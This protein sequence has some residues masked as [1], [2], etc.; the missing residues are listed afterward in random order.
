MIPPPNTICV[1][2]V[3]EL[4]PGNRCSLEGSGGTGN[5]LGFKSTPVLYSVEKETRVL[6]D[7]QSLYQKLFCSV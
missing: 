5:H 4:L 7:S 6:L 2:E 3:V 1:L